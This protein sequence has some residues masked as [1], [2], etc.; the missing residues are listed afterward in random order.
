MVKAEG[1]KEMSFNV[2]SAMV[3]VVLGMAVVTMKKR[4]GQIREPSNEGDS[5]E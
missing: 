2:E 1:K 3:G 4:I 5:E